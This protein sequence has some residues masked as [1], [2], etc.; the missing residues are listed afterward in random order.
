M[1]SFMFAV[2]TSVM[3]WVAFFMVGFFV[4]VAIIKAKCPNLLAFIT[5][6]SDYWDNLKYPPPAFCATAIF[7]F[8]PIV[9]LWFLFGFLF[10]FIVGPI[11]MNLIK[12]TAS[13]IPTVKFDKEKE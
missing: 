7:V 1:L 12:K 6:D 5:G 10:K 13:I 3:F 11:F 4:G 8:W 2:L 9:L